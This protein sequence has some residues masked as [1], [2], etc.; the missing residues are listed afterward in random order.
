[1]SKCTHHWL[2]RTAEEATSQGTCIFCNE[3]K[4]FKNSI[5]IDISVNIT[6]TS[7]VRH[8]KEDYASPADKL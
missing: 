4:E 2:I 1:M 6:P 5:W 3:T 8:A 7:R